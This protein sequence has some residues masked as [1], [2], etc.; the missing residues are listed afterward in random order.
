MT[1]ALRFVGW[2]L[3]FALLASTV[4]SQGMKIL[5]RWEEL[6]ALADHTGPFTEFESRVA[7]LR[8]DLPSRG[9]IHLVTE[10]PSGDWAFWVYIFAQYTLAPLVLDREPL[11]GRSLVMSVTGQQLDDLILSH[12]WRVLR[13]VAPNIALVDSSA[14]EN[15]KQP[16]A[17]AE[18][19]P[20]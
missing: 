16:S 8:G 5:G 10:P 6:A 17:N 15:V 9:R 2:L 14:P 20:R 4:S 12:N 7:L 11:P 18:S 13:R 1:I 3:I 19:T